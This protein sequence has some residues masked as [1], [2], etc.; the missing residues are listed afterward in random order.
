MLHSE[1]ERISKLYNH[2]ITDQKYINDC[3]LNAKRKFDL[4]L[5]LL[6]TKSTT[7]PITIN[8][9]PSL[10]C[11]STLAGSLE[12]HHMVGEWIRNMRLEGLSDQE[13]LKSTNISPHDAFVTLYALN[14]LRR[15]KV[16]NF[17]FYHAVIESST[18]EVCKNFMTLNEFNFNNDSDEDWYSFEDICEECDFEEIL[19]YYMSIL[20]SLYNANQEFE[21]THYELNA[22]N[23]LMKPIHSHPF[24]VEYK[25]EGIPCWV[26]NYGYVPLITN[27]HKS[28]VKV[29]AD[30]KLKSFGYNDVNAIPFETKGI[31]T[32]R[33]FVITD[34]YR[35]LMNILEI[36]RKNDIAVYNKFR[37]IFEFFYKED[38]VKF[39]NKNFFIPYYAKI[40]NLNIKDFIRHIVTLYPWIIS[41]ESK[42]DVL[43]CIGNHLEIKSKSFNYYCIKNSIQLY[44]FLK[45]YSHYTD[46]SN[47]KSIQKI[48]DE[49]IDFYTKFFENDV[50][51]K[52]K[53]LQQRTRDFLYDHPTLYEVTDNSSIF[54]TPKYT[55]ILIEYL[56]T[57]VEYVNAWEKAKTQYKIFHYIKICNED[58]SFLA[59]DYKKMIDD[60]QVY[61]DL[62]YESLIKIR[63]MFRN[64]LHLYSKFSQQILFLETLE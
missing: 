22:S 53:N 23:I 10:L 5:D 58:Y 54:E 20:L 31:Y 9:F 61:Y 59:E 27:H 26:T 30:G 15:H 60:N 57:A 47:Q 64:N 4:E 7:L 41:I 55:K 8:D 46:E 1:I 28:Y 17:L 2:R 29:V 21:Y 12:S 38:P 52:E 50:I 18:D 62:L 6:Y 40:S 13:I 33:G 37:P 45:F 3:V 56:E 51:R 35:L 11:F 49:G 42:H 19:S 14:S 44:D 34:A 16:P 25:F 36:T 39:L 48:M 32:D 63:T 24:D 43:R